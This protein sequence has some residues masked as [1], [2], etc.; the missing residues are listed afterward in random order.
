MAP[1]E[2]KLYLAIPSE[3]QYPLQTAF[4]P[5]APRFSSDRISGTRVP[6]DASP[7]AFVAATRKNPGFQLYLKIGGKE[8]IPGE[9]AERVSGMEEA[10]FA[11]GSKTDPRHYTARHALLA[12]SLVAF[13]ESLAQFTENSPVQSATQVLLR[14]HFVKRAEGFLKTLQLL[15]PYPYSASNALIRLTNTLGYF[16][17]DLEK[18]LLRPDQKET[19]RKAVKKILTEAYA[20]GIAST[21]KKPEYLYLHEFS[22]SRLLALNPPVKN[23]KF[24]GGWRGFEAT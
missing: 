15:K 3:A 10:W 11:K 1:P 21:E 16:L 2:T 20:L 9:L 24:Q 18:S 4:P 23:R 7:D 8:L 19:G 13:H 5:P 17:I 12:L 14:D 6:P 22:Q